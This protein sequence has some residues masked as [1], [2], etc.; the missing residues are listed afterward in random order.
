MSEYPT[1]DQAI[2]LE[3]EGHYSRAL[4][5]FEILLKSNGHD[6]GDLLFHCGWCLENLN[7]ENKETI[8]KFYDKAAQT[9]T[10]PIS[11]MNS[12]FRSGWLMMQEKDYQGAN[13]YFHK[14]MAIH[15]EEWVDDELYH[16]SLYWHQRRRNLYH[17]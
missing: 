4:K 1:F 12:Y 14:A 6:K 2:K 8:L 16:Q 5:L 17:L 13:S 10:I 11:R 9:T 7:S 15:E 3:S